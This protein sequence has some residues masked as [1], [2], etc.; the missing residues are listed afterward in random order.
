MEKKKK[1]I[2][3]IGIIAIAIFGMVSLMNYNHHGTIWHNPPDSYYDVSTS[4]PS[5]VPEENTTT[6]EPVENNFDG[7]GVVTLV[8]EGLT[9]GN[10]MYIDIE[11]DKGTEQ[12]AVSSMF[13]DKISEGDTIYFNYADTYVDD[14]LGKYQVIIPLNPDGSPIT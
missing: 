3:I 4:S 5:T 13:K 8:G 2:L 6:S 11:T 7:T 1:I 10:F 9:T 14:Y 12:L